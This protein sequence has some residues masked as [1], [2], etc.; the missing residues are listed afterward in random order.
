MASANIGFIQPYMFE[1][2]TDF[3]EEKEWITFLQVHVSEW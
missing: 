1:S 3:K 2:E